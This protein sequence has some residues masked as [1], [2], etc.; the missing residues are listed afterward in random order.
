[1]TNHVL[2]AYTQPLGLYTSML[3]RMLRSHSLELV[4]HLFCYSLNTC[5]GAAL[6]HRYRT[7][8]DSDK[9]QMNVNLPT[10]QQVEAYIGLLYSRDKRCDEL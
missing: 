3:L 1:M 4:C 7:R 6:Y 9:R 2:F 10:N 5:G 8:R